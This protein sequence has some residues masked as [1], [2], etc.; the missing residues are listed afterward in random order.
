MAFEF[1]PSN[2]SIAEAFWTFSI[3]E[4]GVVIPFLLVGQVSE[5]RISLDRPAINFGQVQIGVQGKISLTLVNDEHL[6]FAFA[7]DKG[8]YDAGEALVAAS[9]GSPLLNMQPSSGMIP[10][11]SQASFLWLCTCKMCCLCTCELCCR[12]CGALCGALPGAGCVQPHICVL[13]AHPSSP[14]PPSFHA[15]DG[16]AGDL[17]TH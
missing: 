17:Y 8:S 6:P 3:P 5:P 1:T 16:A 4:Q 10:P 12:V 13:Y 14:R 9:G 15:P 7:W 2:D 11:N